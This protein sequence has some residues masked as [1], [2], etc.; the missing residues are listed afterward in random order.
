MQHVFP[1]RRF[2]L[3]PWLTTTGLAMAFA[4]AGVGKT[5]LALSVG[6]A[7]A[8]G[9][10][11][12]GW[13]CEH[14]APVLYVDGEM[15][16]ELL[17]RWLA[18]LGPPPPDGDF[19]ILSSA[20]LEAQGVTMPDLATKEGREFVDEIIER[21]QTE[22]VILD[23]VST[24][25]RTGIENDVESWREL[26]QWSLKH[27]QRGRAV[28]YLHHASRSGQMRGTSIREVVV[29]TIIRLKREPDLSTDNETAIELS[30]PKS[31]HFFGKD[32]VPQI[33]RFRTTD[34]TIEWRAEPKPA[35]QQDQ[36]ADM[37]TRG[38][39]QKQIAEELGLTEAR[40]SQIAHKLKKPKA[41]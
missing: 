13:K 35:A 15:P 34:G 12:L 40:I 38:M 21:N 28:I 11:L 6:Y 4:E 7:V 23:S 41:A 27:R 3:R 17:Q 26:Q 10:N 8:S 22:L 25:V 20:I 18:E 2:L 30:F 29:D 5:R 16:G 9:S 14:R 33:V 36:V 19:Q 24:L 31:R 1:P 37:L 32:T 39:T